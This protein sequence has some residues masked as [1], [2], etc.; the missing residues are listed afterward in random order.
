MVNKNAR[1]KT[2]RGKVQHGEATCI[3]SSLSYHQA[4][5]VDYLIWFALAI[6]VSYFKPVSN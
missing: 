2:M 4:L 3:M 6:N 5:F 1:M